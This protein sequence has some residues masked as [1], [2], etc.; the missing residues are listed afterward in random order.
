MAIFSRC[1]PTSLGTINLPT[2]ERISRKVRRTRESWESNIFMQ[3]SCASSQELTKVARA[4]PSAEYYLKIPWLKQRIRLA[5]TRGI[6]GNLI[7][8]KSHPRQQ[9]LNVLRFCYYM[10]IWYM[11]A[12][13]YNIIAL[14]H[15]RLLA[16]YLSERIVRI[17]V[18]KY[19][20][21]QSAD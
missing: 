10:C 15:E 1:C 9:F 2:L 20:F 12:R 6:R 7:P 17:T 11:C 18:Y 21:S 4:N 19:Y 16:K 14:I 13:L 5:G 8:R 3:Q